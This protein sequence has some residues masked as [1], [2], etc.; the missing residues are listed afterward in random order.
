MKKRNMPKISAAILAVLLCVFAGVL[1][2]KMKENYDPEIFSEDYIS[3]DEIKQ[4]MVFTVYSKE[5]WD[6]WFLGGK[7]EYLTQSVLS[8]LLKKLGV[9][10]QINFPVKRKNAAV[11]RTEWDQ[12]YEQML[13]LLDMER[14][15][16][17]ES[18]LVLNR[19]EMENQTVLITNQGDFYTRLPDTYFMDWMSYDVYIKENQ[20]IGVTQVSKQEQT[21]ENVYLKSCQD[22]QIVFLSA[23]AVYEKDLGERDISCEPGVCDLVFKDGALTAIKTKQDII[24]GQMLS[25][26]DSQIEIEDYGRIRHNG[27]LPVYQTYGDVSEKSISDIVLGNMNVAYVTAGKEVC[28]ILILQPADIKNI[29]VL[30]LADDGTNVREDVYLKCSAK[31]AVTCGDETKSTEPEELLHPADTLTESPEKTYIVKPE[32]ED[33]R[34]YLCN[35]DGTTVSNGYSGTVEVRKTEDGYTVVNELPL[36]EYLYAVVPS[37]MPSSFSAEALKTQAVCARSY[38]Y[39]QLMRADLAAYG[40]HINDSTSYQVYNKVEKTKESVAAVDAT[41]GQVLTWNGKVVEAYYFSTSMGYTDTTE[42]WNVDDLSAYGYLKKACLNQADADLDLSDETAFSQYIK[43]SADGYDSDIRYYRWF[44]VADF[45]DKTEQVNEI[46]MARHSI[47]PKNVLYYESDGTTEMDASAAG[48]KMGAITGMSVESRS[49]S[50]SILTLVL[51]YENGIVKVKTEYNIR[52][53]L[54]CIVKKIVY[55]DATESENITM[56]PSAFSTVEKQEDGSY[57]LSGGGYGHGLGMS[58]NG[59]NGMAKAGMGYQDILNYFY[60]D[61]TVETIGE[62]EGK[63]TL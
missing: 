55:A 62:M 43:S 51:T 46:L 60:R 7:Q 40:A 2:G 58:Q 17:K 53:I 48:E 3:I 22:E 44:A 31:A 35:G 63:E 61:I 42:I 24:Q 16:R 29:R 30:L 28:A 8:E 26:D 41:C 18:L 59:A 38:A 21:V 9:S 34:I 13:E 10:E 33:G 19:M 20:C 5:E 47:S 54:G 14:S 23:G 39:M 4:E 25:Y 15:V 57:L 50:G 12:V 32:S 6:E 56:L 45:S 36:E 52:K 1:I 49:G 11:S 37:E 27:K